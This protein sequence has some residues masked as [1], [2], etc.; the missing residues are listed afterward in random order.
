[1][2][3]LTGNSESFENQQSVLASCDMCLVHFLNEDQINQ[4]ILYHQ[5]PESDEFEGEKLEKI[6][7]WEPSENY[8][9]YK[10]NCENSVSKLPPIQSDWQLPWEDWDNAKGQK[11]IEE[12]E[13]FPACRYCGEEFLHENTKKICEERHIRNAGVVKPRESQKDM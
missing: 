6:P 9:K 2:V 8:K 5:S 11:P 13:I 10:P 4:H 7:I 1:M 3:V 12:K